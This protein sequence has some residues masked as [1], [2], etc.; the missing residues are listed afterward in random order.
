[1]LTETL[2]FST[3]QELHAAW[4]GPAVLQVDARFLEGQKTDPG[5]GGLPPKRA[6]MWPLKGAGH[7]F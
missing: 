6:Q 2:I 7:V 5:H 1:M 3:D 4:H